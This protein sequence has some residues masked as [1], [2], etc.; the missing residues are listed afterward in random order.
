MRRN[1]SKRRRQGFTLME[2][3]LVLVILVI[4]GSF[5]VGMFTNTQRK[6]Q[7]NATRSQIGLFKTPIENYHMDNFDYPPDLESLRNA[8]AGASRWAGPYLDNE[9]PVDSWGNPF[10]YAYPGRYRPESYDIW[11]VGP[12]GA[13]STEDDIGNWQ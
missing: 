3:L 4:L 8:P 7:I 1:S 12:D 2:V 13:D 6:A 10:M 5:A 9:V 11:S